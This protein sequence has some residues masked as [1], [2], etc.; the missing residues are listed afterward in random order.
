MGPP[1]IRRPLTITVWVLASIVCLL[2]SPLL[3]A[4]AK[5]VS[6]LTGR[7]QPLLFAR[8]VISYLGRELAVLLTCGGLWLVT[9]F[10]IGIR[11]RRSQLLHLRLLRWFVHGI[12][13]RVITL[14]V[15]QARQRRWIAIRA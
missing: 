9:G 3:L 7:P 6:A 11:S 8:L 10:G 15:S 14:L 2:V 13:Q 1:L 4:L 12:A 5:I